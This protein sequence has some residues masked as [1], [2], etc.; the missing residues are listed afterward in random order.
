MKKKLA[1]MFYCIAQRLHS[2]F[3]NPH[4]ATTHIIEKQ[5]EIKN[6]Q[7]AT[8]DQYLLNELE[9]DDV[10][11]YLIDSMIPELKKYVSVVDEKWPS[12]TIGKLG[13]ISLACDVKQSR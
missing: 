5:Y 13:F 12:G 8:Y 10:K 4:K 2:D 7:S 3:P 6:I 1:K 11:E 9:P